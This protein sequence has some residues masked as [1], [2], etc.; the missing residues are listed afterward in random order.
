[1]SYEKYK[2]YSVTYSTYES[3]GLTI[4]QFQLEDHPEI[5]YEDFDEDSAWFEFTIEVEIFIRFEQDPETAYFNKKMLI[6]K[7]YFDDDVFLV[8]EDDTE[9]T[10]GV[11]TREDLAQEWIQHRKRFSNRKHRI[12]KRIINQGSVYRLFQ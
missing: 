11:F 12:E 3:Y 6:T 2:G 4:H 1:M 7:E 5:M 9:I 10:E 8:I